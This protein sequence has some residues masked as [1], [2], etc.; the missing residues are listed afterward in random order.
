[1]KSIRKVFR[2]V[3]LAS[4]ISGLS[5]PLASAQEITESHLA[6]ALLASRSTPALGNFDN[7]LPFLAEQVQNRLIRVRPDLHKEIAAVVDDAAV[8]L[9]ARR[10][11][12]DNDVA[13]VWARAFTEDELNE[14]N[15]FFSSDVGKKYKEIAGKTGQEILRTG[16]E[17]KK[18]G[19]EF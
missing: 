7:I 11:D 13:R 8:K 9:V 12:L 14:I 16:A 18:Q 6:A 17:L 4:A 10:A 19:F 15:A 1:M 5:V 3:V 2:A